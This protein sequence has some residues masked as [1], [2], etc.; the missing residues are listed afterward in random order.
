[1]QD[2]LEPEI[3][4]RQNQVELEALRMIKEDKAAEGSTANQAAFNYIGEFSAATATSVS[5]R[6]WDTF[7]LFLVK[8]KDGYRLN[9]AHQSKYYPENLFYPLTWLEEMGYFGFDNKGAGCLYGSSNLAGLPYVPVAPGA[10]EPAATA[11]VA[12]PAAVV[13]PAAATP[14]AASAAGGSDSGHSIF[15]TVL[16]CIVCG[17][18][19]AFLGMRYQKKQQGYSQ[20]Y[21]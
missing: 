13:P 7:Y 11:P 3:I 21:N 5:Q 15:A 19:G 9:N 20:I 6:I 14:V 1:M 16:A 10:A 4:A 17:S 2:E 12:E 8:F 18:G